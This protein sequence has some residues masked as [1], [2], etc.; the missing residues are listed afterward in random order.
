MSST[1][2]RQWRWM[3]G[4]LAASEA[5]KTT[6][7]WSISKRWAEREEG[8]I[9]DV[10][11]VAIIEVDVEGSTALPTMGLRPKHRICYWRKMCEAENQDPLRVMKTCIAEL[12]ALLKA[13][14]E[15]TAVIVDTFTVFMTD[16]VNYHLDESRL[17]VSPRTG[18]LDTRGAWG[19]VKSAAI[20]AFRAI[21]YNDVDL[22]TTMHA[23]VDED[24][25]K[26]K[27]KPSDEKIRQA[28]Q[29]ATGTTGGNAIIPDIPGGSGEF[30]L[31]QLTDI[32]FLQGTT[33]NGVRSRVL[34]TIHDDASVKCKHANVLKGKYTIGESFSLFKMR[35]LL[36]RYK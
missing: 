25:F 13:H 4:L 33:K 28:Y 2:K 29:M 17:R 1:E 3:L 11:D 36:S 15:I 18:E 10:D 5:G 19:K 24:S 26:P 6:T 30:I 35:Q 27:D 34:Y 22:I 31:K 21:L 23:K 32:F 12:R 16:L 8:K 7:A 20:D 9:I 14:P